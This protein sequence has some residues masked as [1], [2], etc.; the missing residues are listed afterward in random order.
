MRTSISMIA[1]ALLKIAYDY[2]QSLGHDPEAGWASA[3]WLATFA[4]S[5]FQ[6]L[7]N[8]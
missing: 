2:C 5:V 7:V 6:D 1:F 3:L 8:K 4:F